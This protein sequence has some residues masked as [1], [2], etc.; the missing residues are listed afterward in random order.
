M[1]AIPDTNQLAAA[2][3]ELRLFRQD[4]ADV[5]VQ[6]MTELTQGEAARNAAL[7]AA[8][9]RVGD[10]FR[11]FYVDNVNGDDAN[12][13]THSEP[14]KTIGTAASRAVYGGRLRI[15]LLA[16]YHMDTVVNF[17]DGNVE[18]VGRDERR[19]ITFA[20]HA[21]NYGN[22]TYFPRFSRPYSLGGM[23]FG[24]VE[25]V[26]PKADDTVLYKHVIAAHGFTAVTFN[27]CDFTLEPDA[28]VSLFQYAHGI[29]WIIQSV[30]FPPEIGG[31][32]VEGIPAGTDPKTLLRIGYTNVATL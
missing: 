17:R 3:E 28:D 30:T 4:V 29:G 24:N 18:I 20:G 2:T 19:K 31:K 16:D 13:G 25:F 15:E 11:T 12:P 23:Y 21:E 5:H 10:T 8:E 22:E 26:F 7:N 6:K 32:W 1:N 27:G 9:Q 14:F